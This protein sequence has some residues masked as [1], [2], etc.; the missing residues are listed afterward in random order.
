[1]ITEW[2]W[3]VMLAKEVVWPPLA[4]H[5]QRRIPTEQLPMIDLL[6]LA[7]KKAVRSIRVGDHAAQY[8]NR[9]EQR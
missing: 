7:K 5:W 1:M 8:R 6:N 9:F 4:A 3:M 2:I